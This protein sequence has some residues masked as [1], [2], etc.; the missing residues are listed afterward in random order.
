MK[1]FNYRAIVLKAI[2]YTVVFIL[3]SC[4]CSGPGSSGGAQSGNQP[5]PIIS[6]LLTIDTVGTVPII[7]N[8]AT[9]TV[10]YIHNNTESTISG[11]SYSVED[12]NPNLAHISTSKIL[13]AKQKAGITISQT[14]TALCSTIPAYGSCPLSFVTPIPASN[15]TIQ[16]A[17][18]LTAFYGGNKSFSRIINYSTVQNNVANSVIV[19][20]GVSAVS[21]QDVPSY[22][23][24]YI[25][26]SGSGQ[27]YTIES[28]TLN[29]PGLIVT[30]GNHL[31]G[32]QMAS[33]AI[34]AI[35]VKSPI[36]QGVG[37]II[38]DL[39]V[40]ASG[41]NSSATVGI[42]S[43]P[44]PSA[45]VLVSGLA[46]SINIDTTHNFIIPINNVGNGSVTSLSVTYPNGIVA[47][48][49]TGNACG[50]T[51]LPYHSCNL[52]FTINSSES[53]GGGVITVNYGGGTSGSAGTAVSWHTSS[54]PSA[55]I[56]SSPNPLNFYANGSESTVITIKNN[57]NESI[58]NIQISTPSVTGS[59]SVSLIG[60][61][62]CIGT[63]AP[64]ESCS[65]AVNV[66]AAVATSGIVS[67]GFNSD[68]NEGGT[69]KTYSNSLAIPY[70]SLSNAPALTIAIPLVNLIGN[71]QPSEPMVVSITNSGN[72]EATISLNGLFGSQ[73]SYFTS[74]GTCVGTLAVNES[75]TITIN[76][77]PIVTES[78]INIIDALYN[79]TYYGGSIPVGNPV[80]ESAPIMGTIQPDDQNMVLESVSIL[81]STSGDG[82]TSESSFVFAG[83]GYGI[84]NQF[85]TL[86][87]KNSGTNP[88]IISGVIDENS[89]WNYRIDFTST[90]TPASQIAVGHTC[91]IIYHNILYENYSGLG[92]GLGISYNMDLTLPKLVFYD[93]TIT[94]PAPQFVVQPLLESPFTGGGTLF[95]TANQAML[96]STLTESSNESGSM[97]TVIN[98]LSNA[99]S[100]NPI[101]V[102]TQMESYLKLPPVSSMNC[103]A[104]ASYD[105]IIFQ[106]CS[107]S[108]AATI[109]SVKYLVNPPYA[110]QI[111]HANYSVNAGGQ[112]ISISQ[113]SSQIPLP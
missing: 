39:N 59:G 36:L 44:M 35:E 68:Y 30:Q 72:A 45:A 4:S 32:T 25:Y 52:S 90:C 23:M 78:S 12:N 28:L 21:I 96:S 101:T 24:V 84:V 42:R 86:T 95:V 108:S 15:S 13:S 8:S 29:K 54:S 60:S 11:I 10:V 41:F 40:R 26:A 113:L 38:A 69:T 37:G 104:P 99:E 75:C 63:L 97:I 9:N 70:T 91:T 80:T 46:P 100:Y 83:Y 19:N 1:R 58:S 34:Q 105:G 87:Y 27:T 20:S 55:Q 77:V 66:T 111:L 33:G 7:G 48:P 47:G 107:L 98:S 14:S 53:S 51:L 112:I 43:L 57:G 18:T 81:N 79:I 73:A 71:G 22:S 74:S 103:G 49:A 2:S 16:G 61:N 17:S 110:T 94:P 6:N 5:T 3:A 92:A 82:T 106:D 89:G 64:N 88:I 102:I 85:I 67:V 62:T 31:V 76:L 93:A 50:S 65:Y 109:G 56:T